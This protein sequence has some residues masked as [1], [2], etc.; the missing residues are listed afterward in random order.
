MQV[1]IAG[2]GTNEL[3]AGLRDAAAFLHD[4]VLTDKLVVARK[5]GSGIRSLG[6][7]IRDD[8]A[9]DT[10]NKATKLA[11]QAIANI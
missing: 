9:A 7:V 1:L 11:E 8:K 2:F 3:V 6:V 10:K 5:V 4:D